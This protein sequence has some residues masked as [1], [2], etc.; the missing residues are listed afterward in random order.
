M[1]ASPRHWSTPPASAIEN[2]RDEGQP[3]DPPTVRV[4]Q[5]I[6]PLPPPV[7]GR[8]VLRLI[9]EMPGGFGWYRLHLDTPV[10]DPYYNGLR[11]SFK[12]ACDTELD[13]EP[14]RRS[15][16]TKCR[17]TSRS[18][19]RARDFLSF[20][21]ALM[22]FASQ[23]YPDWQDRLE[24]DVGMMLLELLAATGDELSYAQDRLAREATLDTATQRRS[25]R[26]LAR[27]V[28]YPLDDGSA[29]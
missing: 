29:P 17:W 16:P 25:L 6:S 11:F 5:N 14:T 13:C 4:L 7:D 24:A 10:V 1:A 8:A 18:T 27:L 19:T 28:D 26:H 23:R 21:Q 22:D 20:R 12:A 3:V 2:Q 9:V 15:A